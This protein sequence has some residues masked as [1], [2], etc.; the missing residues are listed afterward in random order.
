MGR[1]MELLYKI[2]KV[3]WDDACKALGTAP[4]TWQVLKKLLLFIM[5]HHKCKIIALAQPLKGSVSK[6][7]ASKA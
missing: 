1:N 4:F 2:V 7:K 3:K 6:K 5:F